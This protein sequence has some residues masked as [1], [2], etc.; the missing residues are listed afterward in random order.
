M[1]FAFITWLIVPVRFGRGYYRVHP[2]ERNGRLYERFGVRLFQRVLRVSR[3]H[4]PKP[5]PSY[6]PGPA[7]RARRAFRPGDAPCRIAP[8]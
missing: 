4:G 7:A 1:L 6:A 5:F 3:F 8:C 2:F